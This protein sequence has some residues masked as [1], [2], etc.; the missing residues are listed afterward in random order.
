MTGYVLKSNYTDLATPEQIE[1]FEDII[2]NEVLVLKL[3]DDNG[4][5]FLQGP[6]DDNLFVES[7]SPEFNFI[8]QVYKFQ[9]L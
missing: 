3:R 8:K 2:L 9:K 6:C 1:K 5:Y 4:N 7:N